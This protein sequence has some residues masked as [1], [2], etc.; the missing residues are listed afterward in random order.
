MDQQLE[1]LIERAETKRKDI[2]ED[3]VKDTPNFF[4]K[5]WASFKSWLKKPLKVY[6]GFIL[7]LLFSVFVF[8]LG[9]TEKKIINV[10][11][12]VKQLTA[13]IPIIAEK[14]AIVEKK[15]M[16]ANPNIMTIDLSKFE[17]TKFELRTLKDKDGK[18]T[19]IK[20]FRAWYRL[21]PE[22]GSKIFLT[23]EDPAEAINH[24]KAAYDEYLEVAK[25]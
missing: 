16:E 22:N 20:K 25:K 11:A 12:Q 2:K 18:D 21:T 13:E 4:K 1:E 19:D 5:S 24:T 14:K 17:N 9:L 7:I 10:A 23:I 3:I 15:D 8:A 6:E